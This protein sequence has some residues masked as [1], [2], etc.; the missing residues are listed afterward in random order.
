MQECD[1]PFIHLFSTPLGYYI[2][3][4]NT[5]NVLKVPA[6]IYYYLG[7][8][9]V[10]GTETTKSYLQNLKK[11]GFLKSNKVRITKHPLED[12]LP[13]YLDNG[14]ENLV[15]QVTQNCNLRCEYCV[16][17]GGYNTRTHTNKRMNFETMKTAIDFFIQHSKNTRVLSF[18]FYG[19]EPLLEMDLIKKG[20]EYIEKVT[21]GKKVQYTFTTNGT[22]LTEEL[23]AYLVAHGFRIL[24]SIDGP[25]EIHDFH[26][27]FAN[28][29][30]GSFEILIRNLKKL[31]D[32]YPAYFNENVGISTVLDPSRSYGCVNDYFTSNRMFKN[33]TFSTSVI[34]D[35]FSKSSVLIEETFVEEYKY[36][37]FKLF[38]YKL[39]RF[40]KEEAESILKDGFQ[41][42]VLDFDD[43]FKNSRK[44]LPE[45]GHHGG[46]CIPGVKRLFV[47]VDGQF[48]PCEKVSENAERTH[49]G[50][51]DTGFDIESIQYL[52]NLEK[53]TEEK[54]HNC[55]AY[56]LCG[57]CARCIENSQENTKKNLEK[58]C[59]NAKI[60]AE[61]MLKDFSVLKEFDY[62]I[63]KKEE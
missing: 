61:E 47:T 15:L 63:A 41:S 23:F 32:A 35:A 33:V 19:G 5:N 28:S 10:Y 7:G 52:L 30:K 53:L 24:V 31:Q 34:S 3:D 21:E 50:S 58:S 2:Y 9:K 36:D 22:L 39:N 4:V 29:E 48:Y 18:G 6:E 42:S 57:V 38:L 13:F 49:I 43:K 17:S 51:L 1:K 60:N 40:N 54:C 16:Y 27:K 20:V 14:L 12:F 59:E 8:E 25:C 55:W 56:S 62:N 44:H 46:P 37:Q 26:R 45:I 11:E